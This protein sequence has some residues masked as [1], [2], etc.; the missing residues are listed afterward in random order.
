MTIIAVG[1]GAARPTIRRVALTAVIALSA[2]LATGAGV[3]WALAHTAP[4]D[5]DVIFGSGGLA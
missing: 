5:E 2:T 1:R 4:Y 3:L